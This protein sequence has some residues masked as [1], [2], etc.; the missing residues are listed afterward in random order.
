MSFSTTMA[1]QEEEEARVQ[2]LRNAV[3]LVLQVSVV[4]DYVYLSEEDGE[5]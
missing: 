1:L 2:Q 5:N 4:Y 3:L